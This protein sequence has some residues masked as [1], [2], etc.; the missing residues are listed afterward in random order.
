MRVTTAEPPAVAGED[1]RDAEPAAARRSRNRLAALT[2]V[3]LGPVIAELALGSTPMH[4][5]FLLILWLP[6]YGAGVLLIREAVVRTGGGWPGVLLLGV[7]YEL[8]E[9]GIGLQALTSPHLYRAAEWSH[10]VLGINTAYWEANVVYHVVFS[11]TIPI[12]LADLLFPSSRGRPYLGRTG[13]VVAA[14]AAL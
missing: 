7:A 10:R 8:I 14:V 12:L 3:V 11:V 9:D 4:L 1:R 2:L 6:I 13:L 5:A